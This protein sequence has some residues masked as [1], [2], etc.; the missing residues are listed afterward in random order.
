MKSVFSSDM[1]APTSII[2]LSTTQYNRYKDNCVH[3][4]FMYSGNGKEDNHK[5]TLYRRATYG[6]NISLTKRKIDFGN[7]GITQSYQCVDLLKTKSNMLL[8][9]AKKE[10]CMELFPDIYC[11]NNVLTSNKP[12]EKLSSGIIVVMFGVLQSEIINGTEVKWGNDFIKDLECCKKDLLPTYNHHGTHGKCYSF[13]N[14]PMYGMVNDVSVGLYTH[15]KS[16]KEYRQKIIDEKL[17]NI[18]DQAALLI[19]SGVKE[20]SKVIPEMSS[21]LSPIL[22]TAYEI[23]KQVNREVLTPLKVTCSGNWNTHI[24]IDGVTQNFHSEKDCAHTCIHVPNQDQITGESI[25][26]QPCFL[27]MISDYQ[28]LMLPLTSPL[29]F[30]YNGQ[31]ITHRQ[32]YYPDKNKTS[33]K[34]INVSSYGNQ[35]MFNHLRKTFKRIIE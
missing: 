29:S 17:S 32:A 16:K 12:S 22:N 7:K 5:Q 6:K 15:K 8:L 18:E 19:N 2:E 23:Q 27:F 33:T 4:S 14:K 26:K 24:F 31:L 35:K 34:F 25:D 1:K 21:L 30:M 9:T 3:L 28:R 11:H 20:L 13:G 10:E